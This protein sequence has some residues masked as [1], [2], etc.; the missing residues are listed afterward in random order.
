MARVLEQAGLLVMGLASH[1]VG[2]YN[3]AFGI[4]VLD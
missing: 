2:H 4:T 1:G 3:F